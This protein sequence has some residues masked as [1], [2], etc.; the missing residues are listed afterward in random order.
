MTSTIAQLSRLQRVAVVFARHGFADLVQRIGLTPVLGTVIVDEAEAALS[1]AERLR[2][3]FEDLGPTFVKLGQLLSLREDIVPPEYVVEFKKLQDTAARIPFED[4]RAAVE[5][6]LGADPAALFE[7][8]EREPVGSA[9]IA[10]VHRAR[11]GDGRDVVV[12]VQRPGIDRMVE[13]DIALLFLLAGLLERG[14]AEA[15]VLNVTGLVQEFARSIREELDF[16]HEAG[17]CELF[18]RNFAGTPE[19]VLPEIIWDTTT[20]RVLTM[21]HLD[22]I[23][24]RRLDE[25]DARGL[26]RRKLAAMGLRI[27]LRMVFE[28]GFFHADIHG[29]NIF[30]MGDGPGDERIGLIDFGLVG[31]L[32]R[33]LID[34]A[35]TLFID[36]F[37]RD[38]ESLAQTYIRV[39]DAPDDVDTAA[40]AR[41][42]ERVIDP[43]LGRALKE[44]EAGPL[45]KALLDI[46]KRHRIRL[47]QDLILFFKSVVTLEGVG[48]ELDPDFDFTG[49][50]RSFAGDLVARRYAPDRLLA[51]AARLVRDLS[52]LGRQLPHRLS[53]IVDQLERGKI[54]VNLGVRDREYLLDRADRLGNRL[55]VSV[56]IAGALIGGSLVAAAEHANTAAGVAVYL[57]AGIMGVVF[58][59]SLLRGGRL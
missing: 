37:A 30:A 10:Q 6:E 22:G 24:L 56:V 13:S 19:L 25:I 28:H 40:F 29:G 5:R 44:I 16:T 9:S 11:T 49:A 27:W 47:P 14:F 32:S 7:S 43:L 58:L 15:R 1:T 34:D 4:V 3:A 20:R 12:K 51:D 46:A 39:A 45:V 57:T 42:L 18:R 35:A 26:D 48:R 2:R 8:I 41:D 23:K 54:S 17:N 36:L 59:I 38:Y 33:A 55:A 21:T 52:E 53:A 31:R 50:A